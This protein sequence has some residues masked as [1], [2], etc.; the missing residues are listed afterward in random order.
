MTSQLVTRLSCDDARR[1]SRA[2]RAL[3]DRDGVRRNGGAALMMC[4]DLASASPLP[5]PS[6]MELQLCVGCNDADGE[7]APSDGDGSPFVD[8]RQWH[9]RGAV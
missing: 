1:S 6:S 9:G 4:V 7:A 5:C 3:S 8:I 2:A